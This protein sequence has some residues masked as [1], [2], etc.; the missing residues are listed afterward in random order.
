MEDRSHYIRYLFAAIASIFIIGITAVLLTSTQRQAAGDGTIENSVQINENES[1]ALVRNEE[2]ESNL[3]L[4]DTNGGT[5]ATISDQNVIVSRVSPS[6]DFL[7]YTV[8]EFVSEPGI[9]PETCIWRSRIDGS[10]KQQ[11]TCLET[12]QVL[13]SANYD[14]SA[15]AATTPSTLYIVD[16]TSQNITELFTYPEVGID[17]DVLYVPDPFWTDSDNTITIITRA[18]DY[19]TSK[20]TQTY[21]ID[22][23]SGS[24][25][26]IS[27]GLDTQY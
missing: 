19:Y 20:M 15:I 25:E 21:K 8:Q 22:S 17:T 7:V 16:A 12:N 27:S 18:E 24:S 1:I 14:A 10:D 2:G 3:E 23:S 5:I 11:I 4:V 6:G 9:Y 26:L 13:L